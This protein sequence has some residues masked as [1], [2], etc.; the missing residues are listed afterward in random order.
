MTKAPTCLQT[1]EEA[2]GDGGPFTRR[3]CG[4]NCLEKE[5]WLLAFPPTDILG[6]LFVP[7]YT[8]SLLSQGWESAPQGFA[9]LWLWSHRPQEY[10]QVIPA[11]CHSDAWTSTSTHV[12]CPLSTLRIHPVLL[13]D[14]TVL[15]K[16]TWVQHGPWEY[17][18]SCVPSGCYLRKYLGMDYMRAFTRE[19]QCTHTTLWVF[20]GAHSPTNVSEI[21]SWFHGLQV[22][23]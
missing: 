7:A 16:R 11:T 1:A 2:G 19:P 10:I 15:S 4:C 8:D 13:Q 14:S 18:V 9:P 5:A 3:Q 12:H 6:W 22:W 21:R 17:S 20:Q 23:F